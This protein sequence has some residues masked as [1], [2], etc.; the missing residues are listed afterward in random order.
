MDKTTLEIIRLLKKRMDI[1]SEIG[2]LKQ[3]LKLSITDEQRESEIRK[4]VTDLCGEIGL[5][6][7]FALRLLNLMLNESV[8]AQ[9]THKQ[10]HLSLFVKAKDLERQGKKI[11]HMEVGEPDFYPP[12]EVK[13]A[14]TEA[15]D[16]GFTKY[17]NSRGLP[18]LRSAL[19]Q[20]H[21]K[22]SAINLCPE[23]FIVTTG[24]RYAVFLAISTL[25]N[26]GEEIIVTEPAWP[27]YKDNALH[28]GVKARILETNIEE[29]WQ[30]NIDKIKSSINDNT[31]MI[32]LNSPNNPTG[33]IISPTVQD[34]IMEV[35]MKNNLYVLSDEI[36]SN[37][38]YSDW[39][40]V[41]SYEYD[42]SIV[43]QSFSKSHAM[44]GFRIGYAIAYRQDIIEKMNK[45]Q[46]LCITSVSEPTQYVALK[47]INSE[48]VA[49]NRRIMKERLDALAKKAKGIGL[50][51]AYPDGAMYLFAT[52]KGSDNKGNNEGMNSY[53]ATKKQGFDG[54]EFA[55]RLLEKGVAVAPG[56]A[57][58]NYQ[59]FIRISASQPLEKLDEGMSIIE[60]EI[61]KG[62]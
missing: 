5:E 17:G 4:K 33:K 46:A 37:Y 20:K 40:S 9:S 61:N 3:D 57:F 54:T 47:S 13:T 51:F 35:A 12:P 23:N 42:K 10:T 53:P 48:D 19:A 41:L 29:D 60:E 59:N 38:A 18:E 24:G 62:V 26:Q 30:P 55:N 52:K 49:K 50:E 6:K 43:T 2:R 44:T 25:L 31:K 56:E 11:I 7:R 8:V 34:E 58:G 28:S 15:Y 27:A 21:N 14:L 36:Y 16:N 45:V 39:K 32:V 1:S 22:D